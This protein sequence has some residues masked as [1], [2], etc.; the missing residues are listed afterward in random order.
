MQE[1]LQIFSYN[2]SLSEKKHPPG[3]A[4]GEVKSQ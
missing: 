3:A 2:M 4:S 1:I